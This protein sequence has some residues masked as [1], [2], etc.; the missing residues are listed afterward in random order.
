MHFIVA[1]WLAFACIRWGD[2]RNCRK[3]L[4]TILYISACNLLYFY[5]TS[6]YYLWQVIPDTF[7]TQKGVDLLYLFII[8]PFTVVL[9]LSNYPQERKHQIIHLLKWVFIYAG[10]ELIGFY[11]GRI[12]YAHGW[13][14]GWSLFFLSHMFPML[15]LHHIKPLFAYGLSVFW[16]MFYLLMFDVPL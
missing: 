5:L 2:W 14:F 9:F 3:Y 8:L 4:H 15:Y 12:V 7:L 1:I 10:V 16:V 11:T 13:T 6:D